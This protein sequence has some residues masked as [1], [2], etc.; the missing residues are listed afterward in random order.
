MF[1]SESKFWNACLILAG[2]LLVA[3]IGIEGTLSVNRDAA[4]LTHGTSRLLA[5]M[6]LVMHFAETGFNTAILLS[7]GSNNLLYLPAAALAVLPGVTPALGIKTETAVLLVVA[8]FALIRFCRVG[9]AVWPGL[10]LLLPAGAF[11]LAAFP[12]EMYAQR[13]HLFIL[14]VLPWILARVA[15]AEG[16]ENLPLPRGITSAMMVAGFLVKPYFLVIW[17]L[18][19]LHRMVAARS[20]RPVIRWENTALVTAYC[21]VYGG[22][23]ATIVW[24]YRIPESQLEIGALLTHRFMTHTLHDQLI[25]K[26]SLL[27]LLA[28]PVVLLVRGPG[29]RVWLLATFGGV[30]ASIAQMRGHDYNWYPA[31]AFAAM[32]LAWGTA[33]STGWR[34][35]AVGALTAVQVLLAVVRAEIFAEREYGM[36]KQV[37]ILAPRVAELARGGK[38]LFLS[39]NHYPF[40][41]VLAQTRLYSGLRFQTLGFVTGILEP[42]L[43]VRLIGP[44]SEAVAYDMAAADVKVVVVAEGLD[45]TPIVSDLLARPA[46]REAF[47]HYRYVETLVAHEIYVKE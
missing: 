1:G 18:V 42:S 19:E 44:L 16:R 39:V 40:Y 36:A 12:V 14:L 20:L 15:E 38:V 9:R 41:P 37:D 35:W 24:V 33:T 7:M 27:W 46:V 31:I 47:S 45:K 11:A 4:N 29:V 3:G 2:V 5:G 25:R 23:L 10:P 21:V 43:Q 26:L 34:K 13:E 32:T 22:L 30:V 8:G 17:G 6:P 28:F